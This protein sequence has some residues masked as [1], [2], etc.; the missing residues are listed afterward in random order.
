MMTGLRRLRA[1]K[2]DQSSTNANKLD[3][4]FF[5]DEAPSWDELG[6]V[7]D[8]L[9]TSHGVPLTVDLENGPANP[10]ALVRRFGTVDEPPHSPP[11]S[12]SE[13]RV[14]L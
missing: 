12:L 11:H 7:A 13:G 1:M 6:A 3:D 2:D 9:K 10:K 5:E 4:V 8:A 14:R